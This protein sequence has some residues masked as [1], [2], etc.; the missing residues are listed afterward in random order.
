MRRN[1]LFIPWLR[2]YPTTEI[3]TE[4]LYRGLKVTRLTPLNSS[5]YLH[6]LVKDVFVSDSTET[7]QIVLP[8]PA[9]L[10]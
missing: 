4:Y 3:L 1:Y 10:F 6:S 7:L 2:V 8:E 5:R 9:L